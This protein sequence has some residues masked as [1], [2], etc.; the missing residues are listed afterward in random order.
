MHDAEPAPVPSDE[1]GCASDGAQRHLTPAPIRFSPGSGTR[2]RAAVALTLPG[3]RA[4]IRAHNRA[5]TVGMA[6]DLRL[7]PAHSGA[8][9]PSGAMCSARVGPVERSISVSAIYLN[10]RR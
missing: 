2:L 8:R 7:R 1:V 3:A 6:D 10:R 9:D 4:R 5:K